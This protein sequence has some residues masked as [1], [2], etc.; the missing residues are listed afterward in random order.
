MRKEIFGRILTLLALTATWALSPASICLYASDS[1]H[2]EKIN[3]SRFIRLNGARSV[4]ELMDEASGCRA[5]ERY[6]S[7][8]AY[9]SVIANLYSESLS[10][11]EIRKCA[12]ASVNLG[13]ILLG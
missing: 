13:Y 10:P 5:R 12:I 9:Y 3:C 7:A 8:A 4:T 6:D 1:L 11:A 2:S